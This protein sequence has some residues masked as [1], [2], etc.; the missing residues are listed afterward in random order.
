LVVVAAN[1]IP[2][3]LDDAEPVRDQ[4]HSR[5]WDRAR[6]ARSS[7]VVDV[8]GDHCDLRGMEFSVLPNSELERVERSRLG[9][10]NLGIRLRTAHLISDRDG[11]NLPR[12]PAGTLR[13]ISAYG[14]DLVCAHRCDCVPD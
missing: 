9:T 8:A 1:E 2:V 10:R 13:K 3:S 12:K 6:Q 5:S 11:D 7:I 14:L 4:S